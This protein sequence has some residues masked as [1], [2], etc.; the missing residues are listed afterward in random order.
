M[1][2]TKADSS[3][4][5]SAN[6][7]TQSLMAIRLFISDTESNS[8]P[9]PEVFITLSAAVVKSR[10]GLAERR[11]QLNWFNIDVRHSSSRRSLGHNHTVYLL[12]RPA[13][14]FRIDED[15]VFKRDIGLQ[16][17]GQ[18]TTHISFPRVIFNKT[19][20]HDEC[21]DY[22]VALVRREQLPSGGRQRTMVAHGCFRAQ[23]Y[24]MW[25]NRQTLK[26]LT[27][28]QM[29]I[30]GTHNSGMYSFYNPRAIRVVADFKYT[31]EEDIF[32]QLAYGIRCLDLRIS[33]SGSAHSPK[34]KI[35]HDVL[36]GDASVLEVLRQVKDFVEVTNEIVILDLHRFPNGFDNEAAHQRFIDFLRQELGDLIIPYN[37]ALDRSLQHVWNGDG[38]GRIVVCY[39]ARLLTVNQSLH[40]GVRHLWADTNIP[41]ALK[42]YFDRKVCEAEKYGLYYFHAAM[43]ELT[44]TVVNIIFEGHKGGLRKMADETNPRVARWFRREYRTCANIVA[45]DFFLGADI[46][47]VAIHSNIERSKLYRTN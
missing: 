1:A 29:M 3:R 47:S 12:R 38:R 23:P 28:R 13:G 45:T 32:N 18:I 39:N 2:P 8:E 9:E 24:W 40:L 17:D 30:P 34:Y 21:L 4:T 10:G 27:L 42:S 14:L 41:N 36:S 11:I 7:E 35:A 5:S 31:Q 6:A 22:W 19:H 33:A 46:V 43:A 37:T 15:A 20:L 26:H 16:S 25:K 44:P